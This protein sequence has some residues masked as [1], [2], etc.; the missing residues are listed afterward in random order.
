[1]SLGCGWA[2]RCVLGI[3]KLGLHCV[4]GLPF[5]GR[6]YV[7]DTLKL[8]YDIRTMYT[9]GSHL[10][11]V[12]GDSTPRILNWFESIHVRLLNSPSEPSW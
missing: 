6:Y 1:M 12:N 11:C 10:L 2:L 5:V 9:G 7:I 3:F 4:A 8:D